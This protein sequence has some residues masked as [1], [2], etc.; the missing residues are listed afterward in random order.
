ML[1][2]SPWFRTIWPEFEKLGRRAAQEG[3]QE[4]VVEL[5][6]EF[7]I[8]FPEDNRLTGSAPEVQA[9]RARFAV[10]LPLKLAI[11]H[12]GDWSEQQYR[13]VQNVAYELQAIPNSEALDKILRY[14]GMIERELSRAYE[15]LDRLQR[16][17]QGE[18]VPPSLN[19]NVN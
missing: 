12:I 11:A 19:L 8:A 1:A 7:G 13:S 15:R 10:L 3:S 6:Q 4:V 18:L 14:G 2:S 17:R 9:A 16:R 5:A